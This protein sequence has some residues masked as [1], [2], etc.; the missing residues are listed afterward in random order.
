MEENL[1]KTLIITLIIAAITAFLSGC[2]QQKAID[3]ILENPQMKS[4]LMGKMMEDEAIKADIT[5]Q[6]MAD[7]AWVSSIVGQLAE[8]HNDRILMFEKLLEHEG[9]GE[10]M[11]EKMAEDPALKTKI[12]DIAKRK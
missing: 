10:I 5:N 3:Q 6:L 12:K 8:Q 4:Y 11:L 2:D 7:T 1:K 9:M